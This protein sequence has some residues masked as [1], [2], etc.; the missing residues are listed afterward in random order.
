MNIH[1]GK[2]KD[3]SCLF[4]VEQFWKYY[5]HIVRPSDLTGHTD[6]HL[7]KEGI[8][9][10]WEVLCLKSRFISKFLESKIVNIFLAISFKIFLGCAK[11]PSPDL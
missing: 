6:Y 10:M 7:F 4:Q 1:E 9:P 2:G 11:E 5:S 3:V 8:R